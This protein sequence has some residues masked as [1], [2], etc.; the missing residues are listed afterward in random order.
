MNKFATSQNMYKNTKA[1][2]PVY[3]VFN[4]NKIIENIKTKNT[5]T[6]LPIWLGNKNIEFEVQSGF[7][8]VVVIT[9][10]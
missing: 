3:A 2:R 7:R 4:P 8:S 6:A 1:I 5:F 10:A 9:F